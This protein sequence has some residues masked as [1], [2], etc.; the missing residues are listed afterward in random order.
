MWIEDRYAELYLSFKPALDWFAFSCS[1]T[2]RRAYVIGKSSSEPVR[3][4]QIRL[5]VTIIIAAT[6][7]AA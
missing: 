3:A 4:R 2:L 7:L 1:F 6:M 5:T